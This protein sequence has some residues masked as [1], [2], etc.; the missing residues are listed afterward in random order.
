MTADDGP[1]TPSM[2]CHNEIDTHYYSPDTIQKEMHAMIV[3][4]VHLDS[5]DRRGTRQETTISSHHLML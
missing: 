1:G 2:I 5:N 3:I 4:R